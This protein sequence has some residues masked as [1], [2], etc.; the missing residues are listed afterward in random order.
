MGFIFCCFKKK[1]RLE[2][3]NDTK[4]PLLK[5]PNVEYK[6]QVLEICLSEDI[7]YKF[8]L[9]DIK[10]FTDEQITFLFNA[11]YQ[12]YSINPP[13]SYEENKEYFISLLGRLEENKTILQEWYKDP[14]KY[15]IIKKF[16]LTKYKI[17][18]FFDKGESEKDQILNEI[19]QGDISQ[20]DLLEFNN[21]IRNSPE[22]K[23]IEIYTK[24][25]N[26]NQDFYSLIKISLENYENI[27]KEY[28]ENVTSIN[29][30]Y[31]DKEKDIIEKL[32]S[33]F[34]ELFKDKLPKKFQNCESFR[35]ICKIIEDK[36]GNEKENIFGISFKSIYNLAYK[37]KNGNI[38][39]NLIEDI[40]SYYQNPII[41][42]SS[43]ALSFLNLY[44]S[45][46]SFYKSGI[47]YKGKK[48]E[49]AEHLNT[50][51][52]NFRKH[53][54]KI[55]NFNIRNTDNL[56]EAESLIIEI[57]KEVEQ[58]R[59]DI[60]NLSDDIKKEIEKIKKE[61]KKNAGEITGNVIGTVGCLLGSAST[62]GALGLFFL[63]G[64]AANAIATG[65]NA[66]KHVENKKNIK[67]FEDMLKETNKQYK[68][69]QNAIEELEKKY[70]EIQN[71]Y[72]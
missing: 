54:Y 59:I 32:I 41:A 44:Q 15:E 45:I 39:A 48:K 66:A 40:K 71:M 55:K 23:A 35:R 20:E 37:F 38:I 2:L 34:V 47:I 36:I 17:S 21:I 49:F 51:Q 57:G 3:P 50:I 69:I 33:Y 31:M 43:I 10:G 53:I 1:E 72:R 30:I 25:R 56:K 18:D 13:P 28:Y 19:F 9:N 63:M 12:C 7:R 52:S 61:N 26:Y 6:R 14:S 62:G 8:L 46:S 27:K 11:N 65:F 5:K 42:I 67:Y 16:W 64:S 58:D 68:E 22:S 24:L 29:G 4:E 60:I 70:N